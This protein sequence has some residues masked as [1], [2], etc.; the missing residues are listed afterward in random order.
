MK[1]LISFLFL[2]LF[3]SSCTTTATQDDTAQTTGAN[4]EATAS[5][6]PPDQA[7]IAR[8]QMAAYQAHQIKMYT[9]PVNN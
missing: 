6:T 1:K 4:A 5:Q 9:Q 7:E 8:Q 3:L 2:G